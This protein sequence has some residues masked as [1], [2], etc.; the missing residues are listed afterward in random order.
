[1][2]L[3]NLATPTFIPIN[4]TT[5]QHQQ[6]LTISAVRY[7]STSS[8]L[9]W[10]LRVA[11]T[12]SSPSSSRLFD[13]DFTSKSHQSLVH[14]GWRRQ[15]RGSASFGCSGG[16]CRLFSSSSFWR[17]QCVSLFLFQCSLIISGLP[18]SGIVAVVLLL[19]FL[20]HHLLLLHLFPF[21]AQLVCDTSLSLSSFSQLSSS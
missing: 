14:F 13:T 15:L 10:N 9:T 2:Q 3:Y 12:S 21:I 20:H 11:A 7:R 18:V 19:L 4:T 17:A 1:M 8:S 16:I 5:N 6:L